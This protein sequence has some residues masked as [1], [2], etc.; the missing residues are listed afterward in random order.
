ME[1]HLYLLTQFYLDFSML[2]GIEVEFLNFFD[3]LPASC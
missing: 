1:A 2:D 3:I